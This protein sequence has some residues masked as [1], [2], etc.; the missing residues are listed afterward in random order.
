M[1]CSPSLDLESN[2]GEVPLELLECMFIGWS[3]L[4]VFGLAEGREEEVTL[5][6]RLGDE[7][8][9]ADYPS[10]EAL[11]ILDASRR[12]N[13]HHRSDLIQDGLDA[14]LSDHIA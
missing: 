7:T 14:T 11:N 5:I 3:P 12:W 1:S 8:A 4:E 13:A 10:G 6:R 9:E 2:G